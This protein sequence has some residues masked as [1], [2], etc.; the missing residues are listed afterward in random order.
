M[1]HRKAEENLRLILQPSA[2]L[3][4]LLR[5]AHSQPIVRVA[6]RRLSLG[7]YCWDPMTHL[8]T[9]PSP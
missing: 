2:G 7:P 3:A 4:L 9:L 8:G 6:G 1:S 5:Q